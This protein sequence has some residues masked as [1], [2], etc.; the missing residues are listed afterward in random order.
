MRTRVVHAGGGQ[1]HLF[2]VSQAEALRRAGAELILVDPGML[3]HSGMATGML[4]G[5]HTPSE[6]TVDLGALCRR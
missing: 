6:D 2:V 1:A 3:W 5:H 4:S